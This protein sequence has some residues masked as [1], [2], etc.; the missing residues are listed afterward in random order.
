MTSER[1]PEHL[2]D[3]VRNH[4]ADTV[5]PVKLRPYARMARFD[6]PIGWWLL[7]LPCWWA[8]TLAAIA[9]AQSLNFL[10]MALFLI[11]AVVMRGA[12]CTYNDILDRKLDASVERT[13]MR[14]LAS[15]QVKVWQA[16]LFTG[17]LCLIGLAVLLSFNSFT[18]FTGF[19]SVLLVLIYPLMKRFFWVP[20]LVLGLAFNWGAL[21]GWTAVTGSLSAAPILLY[22]CGIFWTIGYDT[23]YALQDI[24]DDE[25]VGIKSSARF[26]GKQVIPSIAGCYLIAILCAAGSF[27]LAGVSWF[28]YI[29]LIGFAAHLGIQTFNI[30]TDDGATCLKLFRSNRDAGLLLLCGMLLNVFI[31]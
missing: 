31:N 18:I 13:K 14:P 16:V 23:I 8:A 6:R 15:G 12:G 4:W 10:Y 24:E 2:P 30:K 5:I 9:T 25:I 27:Y 29:G 3:A 19:A 26:F 11:G 7:L 21:V 1:L 17:L 22:I 20:Q 28:S